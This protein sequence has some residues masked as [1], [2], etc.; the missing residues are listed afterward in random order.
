MSSSRL[1]YWRKNGVKSAPMERREK[2]EGGLYRKTINGAE[3]WQ[4]SQ[5]VRTLAGK[6]RRITGTGESRTLAKHRLQ[7][8]LSR[9]YQKG[10]VS[11]PVRAVKPVEAPLTVSQ[12]AYEWHSGLNPQKVS[13]TVRRQY[14]RNFELHILPHI[15]DVP[16]VDVN[17]SVVENLVMKILP[18]KT[19]SDGSPLLSASGRANVFRVL[20]LM[21][22]RAVVAEKIARNPC[23]G[24]ERPKHERKDEKVNQTSHMALSLIKILETHPDRARHLLPFLGLRKSEKLGLEWS[25][26]TNLNRT[27][28]TKLRVQQQLARHDDGSGYYIKKQTKTEAS[29][30]VIPL[31]DP[32]LTALREY[33]KIQ[34]GWKKLPQWNP[35]PQFADLI[36][37]TPTGV[38]IKHNRDNEDWHELLDANG[39]PYWRN[40]LNRH[41]TATLLAKQKPPVPLS[42]V[43]EILGHNSEAMSQ[44]YTELDVS[45]MVEP[46][47][48]YGK[49]IEESRKK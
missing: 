36:F 39:Y 32:W 11:V 25:C 16:L 29:K 28:Q 42:V 33:K 7:A 20:N 14:R 19:K 21:M 48:N 2:G 27:G 40:H 5:E 37:T 18:A 10:G 23:Q 26:I 9:F 46:L 41:I 24:A 4:A 35:E 15:G 38:P 17:L 34:D 1:G 43:K 13:D 22:N 12:W 49:F 30:R 44:Y 47:E 3:V 45:T 6:R 31:A 8:N